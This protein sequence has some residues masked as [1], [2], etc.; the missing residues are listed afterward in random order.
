VAWSATAHAL[1]AGP[2]LDLAYLSRD[3]EQGYPGNLSVRV[4]Y[5]PTHDNELRIDSTA[6]TDRDTIIN[7]TNHA[8]WNLAGHDAGTIL[9]HQLQLDADQFAAVGDG[10]LPTGELR[11]VA[12]TPLDFT[13][14]TA[15][16]ARIDRDDPQLR[17]AGGYDH[18]FAI[19]GANGEL[20]RA[21]R[22]AEPTTGRVLEIF[23]TEPAIQLYTGNFLDGFRGKRGATYHRRTGLCLETQHHPDSPN[24][25]AF[26]TVVLRAGMR[27]AS[28][29][30]HRFLVT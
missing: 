15:I 3:G 4:R 29:T 1:P 24:Q 2:A 5:T 16:G 17:L 20:R 23:T 25:P 12:G 26:P 30:V 19:R 18:S 10:L 14:A 6:T 28:T 9:D 21:A 7:L 11:A 27:H 22:V 13:R 8:Y